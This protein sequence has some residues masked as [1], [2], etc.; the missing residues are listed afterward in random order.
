MVVFLSGL[1]IPAVVKNMAAWK[2]K[3]KSLIMAQI[4]RWRQASDMQVERK[5]AAVIPSG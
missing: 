1:V 3:L 4:E 5:Q 2:I